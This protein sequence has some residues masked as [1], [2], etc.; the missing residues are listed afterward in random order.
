MA[1]KTD[2]TPTQKKLGDQMRAFRLQLRMTIPSFGKVIGLDAARIG[3]REIYKAPW[4]ESEL[5]RALPAMSQ[6]LQ[7]ALTQTGVLTK[8]I[9][10]AQLTAPKKYD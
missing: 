2:L 6:H 5:Q 9:L 3:Q 10:P 8:T 4:R 7:D 1:R